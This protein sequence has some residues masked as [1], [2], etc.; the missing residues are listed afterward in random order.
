[1]NQNAFPTTRWSL[2]L[3]RDGPP[4]QAARAVEEICRLYWMPVFHFIKGSGP[5]G[6]GHEDAED[7]TQGFFA[8]LLSNGILTNADPAKGRL[9]NYL[10]GAVKNHLLTANRAAHAKKRGGGIQPL[11]LE[12]AAETALTAEGLL[13]DEEFD[14]QWALCLLEQCL[15]QLRNEYQAAGK[16]PLYLALKPLLTASEPGDS[17]SHELKMSPGALRVAL[18]RCRQRYHAILTEK[19]RET[20]LPGMDPAEEMAAL[21]ALLGRRRN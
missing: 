18:Y 4:E 3:T 6:K 10:L 9:R 20:L 1:M 5:G 8:A 16:E 2:I 13:P 17:T 21:A 14:R 12:Q 7:L 15:R 19:V 11:P